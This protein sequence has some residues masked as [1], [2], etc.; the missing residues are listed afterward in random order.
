MAKTRVHIKFVDLFSGIGGFH[1]GIKL[2]AKKNKTDAECVLAVEID[3]KATN[4]YKYNFQ[5]SDSKM[6]GDITDQA[7]KAKVPKNIDILCAGFPC[8]PF[9][10]AGHKK[11]FDDARGTLFFD[12]DKIIVAKQPRVVFL[13]NVRNLKS[14]DDGYT[15]GRILQQL[16]KRGYDVFAPRELDKLTQREKA[17]KYV[18]ENNDKRWKILRASDFG[19]P[20]HRP[21]IYIVAFN[22]RK[23]SA[24]A[25]GAFKFPEPQQKRITLAAALNKRWPNIIGRTLRV[26][27]RG[28]PHGNRHNWDS[29]TSADGSAVLIIGP[30]EG[31]KIMG[32]PDNFTFP[33]NLSVTQQMKQLGNSVAVPV[34]QAIA[35][36]II[37]TIHTGENIA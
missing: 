11:G 19:T 36:K 15:L 4:T 35:E 37:Q 10:Q 27:G 14:H 22:K 24:K 21:R 30:H 28:S 5:I 12:I 7:V 23:V 6:L 20:T 25:R 29:Y 16:N 8:Q 3:E 18:E 26:G 9:S 13:E 31:K 32:F 34:I 2:A 1:L 17:K 33:E